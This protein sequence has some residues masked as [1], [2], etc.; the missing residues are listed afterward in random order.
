[1]NRLSILQKADPGFYQNVGQ[2][3]IKWLDQ[4]KASRQKP[5]SQKELCYILE[6]QHHINITPPQ[7]SRYLRGINK[8]PAKIENAI[9]NSLGFKSEYF[10]KH[11]AAAEEKF[12]LDLLTKEDLYKLIHEQKLLI[13]EWKEYGFRNSELFNK[14]I[15]ENGEL[16][17]MSRKLIE[18]NDKLRF[19]MKELK[20]Q[21]KNSE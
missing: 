17:K 15:N 21:L 6:R 5:G 16:V 3:I 2:Y 10:I 1:M 13:Q 18:E 9:T 14:Y 8:M 7:L 4:N 20:K 12:S 11:H 19:E